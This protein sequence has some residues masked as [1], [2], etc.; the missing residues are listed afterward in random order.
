MPRSLHSVPLR[1]VLACVAAWLWL[2]GVEVM[3]NLHVGLHGRLTPHTHEGEAGV[4]HAHD[5]HAAAHGHAHGHHADAA[6]HHHH[7]HDPRELARSLA[8]QERGFVEIVRSPAAQARDALALVGPHRRDDVSL[9]THSGADD[10]R[11][12]ARRQAA[13]TRLDPDHGRHALA[14]RG[15][16]VVRPPPVLPCEAIALVHHL[17]HV[18][19]APTLPATRAATRA[20]ARGPPP[21]A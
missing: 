4:V 6:H 15:V 17:A 2:L 20:C 11:V 14:H 10:A 18:D 12:A 16:A 19:V 13:W 9:A 1:R 21:L 7:H 5:D 3:P 8:L